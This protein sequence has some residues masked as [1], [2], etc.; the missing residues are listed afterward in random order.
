MKISMIIEHIH[1]ERFGNLCERD[2][3]LAPG[4]NIIEGNNESGKST[5]AG[6]IKFMFYGLE[7]RKSG[8]ALSER[9]RFI[10]WE[11]KSCAGTLS[12]LSNG[13]HYRIERRLLSDERGEL[14]GKA[15]FRESLKV[16]DS[17]TLSEIMK[18][19]KSEPGEYFFGVDS[20]IFESTAFIRQSSNKAG[21][22]DKLSES[23]EN[24]LFSADENTD[25][26]KALR[27]LDASRVALLHKNGK[28][29]YIYELEVKCEQLS[30]KLNSA[31]STAS[32]IIADESALENAKK[33]L[34]FSNE[35]AATLRESIKNFEAKSLLALFERKRELEAQNSISNND[36]EPKAFPYDGFTERIS[37]LGRNLTDAERQ[38]NEANEKLAQ[39]SADKSNQAQPNDRSDTQK[40]DTLRTALDNALET[41][42]KRRSLRGTSIVFF[43]IALIIAF[44]S[45]MMIRFDFPA[46]IGKS[47]LPSAGFPLAISLLCAA[48]AARFSGK[49]K[50]VLRDCNVKNIEALTAETEAAKKAA[51]V[52]EHTADP[53]EDLK[54]QLLWAKS[55]Q[56]TAYEKLKLEYE[57]WQPANGGTPEELLGNVA[58]ATSELAVKEAANQKNAEILAM[59]SEQLASHDESTLKSFVATSKDTLN[60]TL[61]NLSEKRRELDFTEKSA[62]ALEL[63]VHEL[64]KK[65]AALYPISD[66]PARI[67][68]KIGLAR[69]FI[70]KYRQ[71]YDAYVLAEQ[72]IIEAGEAMRS[73]ISPKLAALAGEYMGKATDGKYRLLGVTPA[74]ELNFDTDGYTRNADFLSEG[75]KDIAYLS[76]RLAMSE[77]LFRQTPPPTVFDE[78]FAMLDDSRLTKMLDLIVAANEQKNSEHQY[79]ILTS[80]RRESDILSHICRFNKV[81]L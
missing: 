4:V 69:D 1:I 42:R 36:S 34:A 35:R 73:S 19:S 38:L 63:R 74:F 57:K 80:H 49:L 21:F 31:K 65:L 12:F 18:N 46:D 9:E 59:L 20:K 16:T 17:D 55:K 44:T 7:G 11:S 2:I 28:G 66:D 27:K 40:Y 14:Q 75:T 67:A 6:F 53:T 29:G 25:I 37:E 70:A 13:K 76:L 22:D 33:N 71:K 10:N 61:E 48:L 43:I 68:E 32:E 79:I 26:Q 64:E 23:I 39:N 15:A 3:D 58:K 24:I 41:S 72:K 47:I 5:L 78:S 60:I 8:G 54:E 52:P 56:A 62:K 45:V 50:K 51:A 77:A 81:G 30:E